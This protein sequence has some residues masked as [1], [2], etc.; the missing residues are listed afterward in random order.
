MSILR[1]TNHHIICGTTGHDGARAYVFLVKLTPQAG[2][3]AKSPEQPRLSR[4][5]MQTTAVGDSRHADTEG[6]EQG[7]IDV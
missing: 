7:R 2:T 4:R 1:S 3:G 5:E 6:L